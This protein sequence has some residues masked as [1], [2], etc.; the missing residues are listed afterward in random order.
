MKIEVLYPEVCNLY[1]DL[2]NVRYLQKCCG[3]IEVVE[4]D[5]KS[6]PRFLDE[7]IALVFMGST[8][9]Q[10][11]RLA[12]HALRPY[13]DE[14][15]A[16]IEDGQRMLLTGN[17]MDIFTERVES[18]MAG[19]VEG[20]GIF[21]G[22][23]AYRMMRRH[24]SFFLGDFQGMD[25]V[26]FKSLFGF[27]HGAGG[28]NALFTARRGVGRDGESATEGFRLGNVMATQIIGPLLILNPPLTKWLLREMGCDDTLAFEQAAMDSYETRVKEFADEKRSW[29][30]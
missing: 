14:M 30:Y 26:G 4:T 7:P 13:L 25:I 6:R 28:E 20:L 18:D 24:N 19:T 8:T 27:V 10:G 22:Y 1:G 15:K 21:P 3:A 9:E 16:K 29:K 17:A 12:A 11:I 5:L 2:Q 23:V